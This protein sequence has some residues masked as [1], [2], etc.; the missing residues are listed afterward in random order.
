MD[1][2]VLPGDPLEDQSLVHEDLPPVHH[3]VCSTIINSRVQGPKVLGCR[4]D[5]G[6]C[7]GACLEGLP[8]GQEALLAKAQE[9]KTIQVHSKMALLALSNLIISRVLDHQGQPWASVQWA[10][11]LGLDLK[12]TLV[13]WEAMALVPKVVWLKGWEVAGKMGQIGG[14][15]DLVVRAG[16]MAWVDLVWVDRAWEVQAWVG[17]EWEGRVWEVLVWEDLEWADQLW[18]ARAWGQVWVDR[19]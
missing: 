1:Q 9:A 8:W 5:L 4:M 16:E 3:K 14:L 2:E 10:L 17:R 12:E 18:E 15:E 13:V 6:V 19:A 11:S 7:K